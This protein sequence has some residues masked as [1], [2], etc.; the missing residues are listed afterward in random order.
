MLPQLQFIESDFEAA[1]QID[2]PE[3]V[4]RSLT[5]WRHVTSEVLGILSRSGDSPEPLADLLRD[6]ILLSTAASLSLFRGQ[7]HNV[8]AVR[9]ARDAMGR[10]ATAASEYVGVLRAYTGEDP[11]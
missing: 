6:S 10:A 9:E 1:I 2:H 5:R 4:R 8:A 3:S 11:V 7:R